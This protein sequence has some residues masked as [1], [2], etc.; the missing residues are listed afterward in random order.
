MVARH[1]SE[2]SIGRAAAADQRRR[3]RQARSRRLRLAAATAPTV[4]GPLS[5]SLPSSESLSSDRP[6]LP[7]LVRREGPASMSG[8]S[9]CRC[10]RRKL[11]VAV[12]VA[13]CRTNPREL[14]IPRTEQDPARS[15]TPPCR[16]VL[17]TMSLS[18]FPA[19]TTARRDPH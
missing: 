9:R 18:R 6:G 2:G 3:D 8:S 15:P 12:V 16:P 17:Q 13:G 19:T 4:N 1:V 7:M 11:L 10:R 5:P 14:T